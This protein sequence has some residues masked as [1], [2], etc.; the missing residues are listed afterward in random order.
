[1]GHMSER[2]PFIAP[3]CRQMGSKGYYLHAELEAAMRSNAP[4]DAYASKGGP[5]S[6]KAPEDWHRVST[7]DVH[8]RERMERDAGVKVETVLA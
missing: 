3:Y 6:A 2:Y 5:D 8:G 7:M 4:R 1:M